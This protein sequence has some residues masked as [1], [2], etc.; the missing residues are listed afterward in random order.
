MVTREEMKAEA[1]SRMRQL[2]IDATATLHFEK[3][4]NLFMSR[5]GILRRLSDEESVLIE[6]WERQT[7]CLVYHIIY[8]ET[9]I[10][11]MMNILYVSKY[12]DDWPTERQLSRNGEAFGL[13]AYVRNMDDDMLSDYGLIWLVNNDGL[14]FRV[15]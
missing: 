10:G 5:R 8:S 11:D 15:G 2:K 7:G 13:Y 6:E 14:L 9:D 3:Y 1:L 12:E 4:D